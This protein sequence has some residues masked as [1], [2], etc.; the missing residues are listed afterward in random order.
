MNQNNF[1][2]GKIKVFQNLFRKEGFDVSV[3]GGFAIDGFLGR[4]TREHED[5]DLD[6]VGSLKWNFGFSKMKEMLESHFKD[7]RAEKNRFEVFFDKKRVDLEYIQ[8]LK[9]KK[10]GYDFHSE[11]LFFKVPFYLQKR[12]KLKGLLFDIENPHYIFAI[13][14]L[15]PLSGKKKIRKRD[16]QDIENL[17]EHLDKRDLIEVFRFQLDY[18]E[19]S[20]E[21]K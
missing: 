16:K 10:N 20:L 2:L 11:K 14:Y 19:R 3:G 18:I 12:G 15:M 17:L 1:F 13:K 4:L 8:R 6:I 21:V 5:L 9:A 7:V